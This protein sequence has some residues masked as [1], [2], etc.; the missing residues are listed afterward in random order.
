MVFIGSLYLVLFGNKLLPSHTDVISDFSSHSREYLVEAQVRSK[1]SIIGKT[2]EEA[3]LRNL[4]GLYLVEINR[5]NISLPA[6]SPNFKLQSGD[7]LVFAG[8][9]ATIAEMVNSNTGLMLT[10]VGM[11]TK[12]SHTEVLELVI[13][14]NST[15]INKTVKDT[16]FRAKFDSAIL[17]I[18]R[19]GE[20]LTGKIGEL[21]LKAGDVLLVLVGDDFAERASDTQ[22][23]YL[24]SK[25]REF[26]KL[27]WYKVLALFGGV[28][29]AIIA[30][31]LGYISLF[32]ALLILMIL[33]FLL[34]IA[35]PKDIPKSIDFNLAIII[36]LSLAIGTA[37]IKTG[38]ADMISDYLVKAF[39][40]FGP[41]ALLGG[42]F[43]ITNILASYI[44]NK[45][46]AAIIFPISVTAAIQLGLPTAPFIL[47]VAFAAA[48]NFITPIGYQTNLMVYGPGRYNFK[49]YLKI[50]LPLT[51]IYLVVCVFMLS[52]WF[53]LGAF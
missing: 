32:M 5:S 35:S 33:I 15:L 26:R 14:H 39:I 40:P 31:A 28:A 34:K 8:D 41:V 16:N 9:T 29:L 48:A 51:L 37:M 19:N 43:I 25:I 4:P 46:A 7:V 18:H 45:A 52:W 2:L 3:R 22:D 47:V 44:T 11:F 53:G 20:K 30:S 6:V 21:K 24:I 1:S 38:M 50:G 23:F 12:K 36:A 13:S 10:Q 17:S 42:I 27:K 49:D